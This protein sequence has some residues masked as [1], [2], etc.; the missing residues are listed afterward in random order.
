MMVIAD[1]GPL[2]AL[3]KVQALDLLKNLYQQVITSPTVYAEAVTAGHALGAVD[4]ELLEVAYQSGLLA[5]R[6]PT[7]VSLPHVEFLHSGESESI[8][9]A[10]ELRAD[11]LLMDDYD[12][13]QIAQKNFQAASVSTNIKGTLGVILSAAQTAIISTEQAIE[14]IQ[15]LKS[16]PDVWLAPALCEAVIETLKHGG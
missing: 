8:R 7:L 3:A 9:L 10:I 13:R 4:A 2:L 1:T 12:A 14:I 16:R 15:A 11:W 6:S 5:V